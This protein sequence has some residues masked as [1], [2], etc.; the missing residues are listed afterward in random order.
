MAKSSSTDISNYV[1]YISMPVLF[2]LGYA[3]VV[4]IPIPVGISST[5][6]MTLKEPTYKHAIQIQ[7]KTI[8]LAIENEFINKT[9]HLA[10][11]N[12]FIM[13]VCLLLNYYNHIFF[14]EHLI[15]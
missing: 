6:Y 5:I 11:E 2:T 4:W 12:E 7:T 1:Q 3:A 8:H 14:I 13:F 9:I 15:V 10:I